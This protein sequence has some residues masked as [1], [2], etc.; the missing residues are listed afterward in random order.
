MRGNLGGEIHS[1]GAGAVG[2][3]GPDYARVAAGFGGGELGAAG[4]CE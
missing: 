1:Y 3:S 2:A 4:H